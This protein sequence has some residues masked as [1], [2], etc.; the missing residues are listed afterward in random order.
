MFN[1]FSRSASPQEVQMRDLPAK[2]IIPDAAAAKAGETAKY[3]DYKDGKLKFFNRMIICGI[4]VVLLWCTSLS[5]AGERPIF[6][7][8]ESCGSARRKFRDRGL[9][10]VVVVAALAGPCR[11]GLY[12]FRQFSS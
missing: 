6:R 5:I 7:E 1:K 10:R 4:A 12:R 9:T 3:D 8:V 11:G 2:G